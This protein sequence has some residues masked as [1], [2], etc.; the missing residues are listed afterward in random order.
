MTNS[1]EEKIL[2]YFMVPIYNVSVDKD[3]I[4]KDF[5]GYKIITSKDFHENY[6]KSL[7]VQD[8]ML[9]DIVE[10]FPGLVVKRPIALYLI[11]K[12]VYLYLDP[13]KQENNQ[14]EEKEVFEFDLL[15]TALRLKSEGYIHVNKGYFLS[16]SRYSTSS[17]QIKTMLEA[18]DGYLRIGN[19]LF[20]FEY[21]KPT[22]ASILAALELK[23]KIYKAHTSIYL[24]LSYFN[25][26]YSSSSLLDKIIKLTTIWEASLLNDQ[27]TEIQH[28]LIIRCSCF[29]KKDLRDILRMAYDIRSRVL[30]TG[31]FKDF[32]KLK[33]LLKN[34][35]AHDWEAIF[36]FIKDYLEEITREILI[37]FLDVSASENKDLKTIAA[38][39]D[40]KVFEKFT[41]Q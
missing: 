40:E 37:K 34:T 20:S 26:Y 22:E 17:L 15:I 6:K 23:N 13:R 39:I 24:P 11:I 8:D 18:I 32:D 41:E 25:S 21:Y 36:L 2:A 27:H 4:G 31:A 10:P 29:L 3:I 14:I 1:S 19:K 9:E 16:K 7:F 28:R 5:N 12:E 30:H 33:K 35:T 38:E